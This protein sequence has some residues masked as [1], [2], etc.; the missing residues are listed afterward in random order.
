MAN[1]F[2]A[3]LLLVGACLAATSSG[4]RVGGALLA[5]PSNL[6]MSDQA[7]LRSAFLE[8]A[9]SLGHTATAGPDPKAPLLRDDVAILKSTDADFC[10]GLKGLYPAGTKW[11]AGGELKSEEEAVVKAKEEFDARLAP[12][13]NGVDNAD[14]P[15]QVSHTEAKRVSQTRPHRAV[16]NPVAL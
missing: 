2:H 12:Q 1:A 7:N 13:L 6:R 5:R 15:Y 8:H 10:G 3:L 9:S 11:R 14:K 4:L 16:S